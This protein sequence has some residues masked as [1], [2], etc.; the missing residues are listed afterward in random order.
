LTISKDTLEIEPTNQDKRNLLLPG[1]PLT[2]FKIEPVNS[3]NT[4][5]L[6]D[7][8]SCKLVISEE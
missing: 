4:S 6:V 2:S 7:G 1:I 8:N 5:I 3:F